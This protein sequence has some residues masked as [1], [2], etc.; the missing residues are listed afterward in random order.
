VHN[1]KQVLG[2]QYA[3]PFLERIKADYGW[4]FV[5]DRRKNAPAFLDRLQTKT[6]TTEKGR[7]VVVIRA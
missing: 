2:L 5:F 1:F 6:V 3:T 4:L 7:S